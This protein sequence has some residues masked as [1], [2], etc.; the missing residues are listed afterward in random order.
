[1]LPISGYG[2]KF[3]FNVAFCL[4]QQKIVYFFRGIGFVAL[5]N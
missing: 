4:Y 3:M 2:I 1:M 5:C